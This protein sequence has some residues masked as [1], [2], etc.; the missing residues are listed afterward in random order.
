MTLDEITE[1]GVPAWAA[2]NSFLWL[3]ATNGRSRSSGLPIL[4][5][6]FELMGQWGFR[7]YTIITWDKG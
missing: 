4:Q 6:A 1:V 7:Y 5:Q 2:D 3:W